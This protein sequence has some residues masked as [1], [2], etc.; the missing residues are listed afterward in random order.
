M[1]QK[2]SAQ[3]RVCVKFFHLSLWSFKKENRIKTQ[4]NI[5]KFLEFKRSFQ[6]A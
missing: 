5:N 2:G 6:S 3:A 4:K 1:V